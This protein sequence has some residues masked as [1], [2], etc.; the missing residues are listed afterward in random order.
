MNSFR[1]AGFV[2][3]AAVFFFCGCEE[4]IKPSVISSVN[5]QTLPQ[6]E[7][8]NSTIVVSDSGRIRAI[9]WA[10]YI[11]V[12]ESS[13]VTQM[14]QGVKVRF[15]D[16]EGRQT[17]YLTSEEG[18]VDEVTNNLEAHKHVVVVSSDSSRLKTEDLLWDNRRQLIY[19]PRNEYVDITTPKEKL[20]GRGFESDQYLRNYRVFRV[21]GETRAE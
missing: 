11:R 7:S 5:S 19:T 20:Q 16:A 13:P 6:Q 8:W 21:T 17:S 3:F 4:K 18:S 9:I 1:S 15:F 14:S 2:A 10:G 12:Y